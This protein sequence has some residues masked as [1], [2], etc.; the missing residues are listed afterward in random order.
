VRALIS[1]CSV[2]FVAAQ[3]GDHPFPHY[4]K[5]MIGF[6]GQILLGDM[7]LRTVYE[8]DSLP[9][10]FFTSFACAFG[11]GLRGTFDSFLEKLVIGQGWVMN[12]EAALK[13]DPDLKL[14]VTYHT[15]DEMIPVAASM[16]NVLTMTDKKD[17]VVE[18]DGPDALPSS[19][20]M[21]ELNLNE[22]EAIKVILEK[23]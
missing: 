11:F 20:H 13:K 22:L 2:G 10:L 17:C 9:C 5:L 12:P 1:G 15:D 8:L 6:L 16:M 3:I 21:Y 7:W 19:N 4:S 18:L 14:V 23:F